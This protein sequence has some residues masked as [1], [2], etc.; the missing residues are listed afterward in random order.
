MRRFYKGL[1]SAQRSDPELVARK[2]AHHVSKGTGIEASASSDAAHNPPLQGW[3]K[4]AKAPYHVGLETSGDEFNDLTKRAILVSDTLLLSHGI[5]G[6]YRRISWTSHG[7]ANRGEPHVDAYDGIESW[8]RP[9]A[10]SEPNL[11]AGPF[12]M[13]F[14][15][16]YETEVG[17]YCPSLKELGTWLLTSEPLQ[18]AGLAWYFP[19]YR[20]RYVDRGGSAPWGPSN[21][22][23][24]SGPREYSAIDFLVTGGRAVDL[25]EIKPIKSRLVR[26]ILEVDLPVLEGVSLRDFASITINEFDSYSAFRDSL[27]KRLLNLDTALDDVQSGVAIANIG[28]EIRDGVRQVEAQ[29]QQLRR[30]RAVSVT[31]AGVG[32][33]A[34]VLVAVY[35]PALAA[36]VSALGV[37]GMGVWQALQASAETNLKA[38]RKN[39]WYYVW[40]ISRR[41]YRM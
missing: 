30:R 17:F 20:S 21:P 25:A 29:M 5:Q 31:G 10:V 37:G 22:P 16:S 11:G 4:L 3:P 40:A 15:A 13:N 1:T 14:P 28:I 36:V 12:G 38:L 19:A 35:G 2:Y 32:S 6:P 34:G 27:R 18:R 39:E 7:R 23:T 26:P 9:L 24:V 8:T 41:N 33:V